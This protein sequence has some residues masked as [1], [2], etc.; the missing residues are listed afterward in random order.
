[1]RKAI[2]LLLLIILSFGCIEFGAE[3]E[4]EP[5]QD[6]GILRKGFVRGEIPI[7]SIVYFSVLVRNNRLG[8]EAKNIIISLEN[9]YPFTVSECGEKDISPDAA[10]EETG[11]VC[12]TGIFDLD[13]E[14][15]HRQHGVSFMLPGE[16][17]DFFW[18]LKAPTNLTIMDMV[19]DHT[20]YFT[21]EY[22]YE[23][24][25]LKKVFAMSYDEYYR[26]VTSGEKELRGELTASA[27]AIKIDTIIDEPARYDPGSPTEFTMVITLE[28]VGDGLLMPGSKLKLSIEHP[29]GVK[30]IDVNCT[31]R[32]CD[33]G[34]ISPGEIIP[35]YMIAVRWK[36][37]PTYE[38]VK[39]LSFWIR[40]TYKYMLEDK[41]YV[42]VYPIKI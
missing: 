17:I 37:D 41:A 32:I 10:R 1:M 4:L 20:I 31:Q 36:L 29:E 21:I 25:V 13:E 12:L 5:T 42:K 9:V 27:G 7:D 35:Q 26:R 14:L 39:V 34:E 11:I 18:G 16:E 24:S 2:F 19:Y 28:N 30:P 8:K 33:L 23:V 15:Q 3:K 38:P 22:E 40:A 6:L